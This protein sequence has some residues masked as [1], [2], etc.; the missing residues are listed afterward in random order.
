[1]DSSGSFID[2]LN[3]Y[4]EKKNMSYIECIH[5]LDTVNI[6][7]GEN[8]YGNI[9]YSGERK[10]N[11][12]GTVSK[13]KMGDYYDIYSSSIW[14]INN[15]ES[16]YS[17]W[18]K[19]HDILNTLTP[20]LDNNAT[21][22]VTTP[23]LENIV[24]DI[25]INKIKDILKIIEEYEYKD[26]VEYNIDLKSLHNIKTELYELDSMIGMET[27]KQSILDQLLYF[28]Q[29]L[30]VGKNTSEY[31]H[32]V[33]YG[34]PGTGKTEIAKIIGVMYSK[35]GVLKNN[36]F[37]KVSRNDLIAGYLGQTALKTRAVIDECLGGVLFIDEAYSLASSD[38]NDSFS[39]ECID[40]LCQ[41]MSDYKENLMV[42]IAG[43]EDELNETFFRANRGLESRFI[44]RFK[45]DAY[46]PIEMMKI[47]Q[48]KVLEQEWSFEKEDTLMVKWFEKRK[49]QFKHF[50]R[51]MEILLSY[52]KIVHGRRIYGK[53]RELRR[54]ITLDDINSGYEMFLKNKESKQENTNILH[55]IYI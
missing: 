45:M 27:L 15:T 35:L 28:I 19:S 46:T 2:Y 44:W 22:S 16:S 48:K 23:K 24:I 38:R 1:M 40:I 10:S 42:I 31:K 26:H 47:F 17:L 25:S 12:S 53:D 37:K 36:V 18:Q 54:V 7:Y 51:D 21:I 30:H 39:K 9:S 4:Q 14:N 52:T 49:D 33:L 20:N 43:Y 5:F 13:T 32:T 3:K 41:A 34:S 11:S 8:D 55:T 50:G 29:E 6:N